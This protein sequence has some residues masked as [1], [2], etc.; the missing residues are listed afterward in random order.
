MRTSYSVR[1]SQ[2]VLCTSLSLALWA[3]QNL[4]LSHSPFSFCPSLLHPSLS[5]TFS[6]WVQV[7]TSVSWAAQFSTVYFW[8]RTSL[9][10]IQQ[11]N[12]KRLVFFPSLS[13][14]SIS[15]KQTS[16]RT[17][18]FS[19]LYVWPTTLKA[20]KPKYIDKLAVLLIRYS[21]MPRLLTS[22]SRLHHHSGEWFCFSSVLLSALE[23][24]A[25]NEHDSVTFSR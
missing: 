17:D 2:F 16:V 10:S 14:T 12:L 4:S 7:S 19:H 1:P 8:W 13:W 24:L 6:D 3:S 5:L 20:V 23:H 15:K 22:S 9:L 11:E 18:I 25:S 21:C